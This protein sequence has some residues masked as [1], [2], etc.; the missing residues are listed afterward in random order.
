MRSRWHIAGALVALSVAVAVAGPTRTAVKGSP[1]ILG[2]EI[3]RFVVLEP[4][5]INRAAPGLTN[6]DM[7]D[8]LVGQLL[9]GQFVPVSEDANGVYYQASRGFQTVGHTSSQPAGLY[10]SKT[11]AQTM[12]AY[13]GEAREPGA[14]LQLDSQRLSGADMAKLKIGKVAAK[15]RK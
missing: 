3:P 14:E 11:R 1:T 10:V 12:F 5:R 13:V 6:R 9:P 15:P 7:M 8:R 2:R 4:I